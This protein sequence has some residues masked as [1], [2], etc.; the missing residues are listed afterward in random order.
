NTVPAAAAATATLITTG[1]KDPNALTVLSLW[2][3]SEQADFQK[4]LDDFTAQTG[5]KT[6]YQQ[7]RDFIP[8]LR[9]MIAAGNP[10]MVAIIPRPGV[11]ADLVNQNSLKELTSLGVTMDDIKA[12]YS[13]AWIDLGSANNKLYGIAVKAN[14][15]STVWYHP[16]S[17][18]TNNYQI[19]KTWDEMLKLSD[20]MV[21]A[22][23]TPWAVGAGDSWTLTDWFEI[24]YL[25]T[26]GPDKYNQLFQT[27]KLPFTDPTVLN[28]AQ[29]MT[30]ITNT[31]KY[32]PGDAKSALGTKF[33]DGIGLAFGKSPTAEM[34]FE[35]GFVGGIA[36]QQVNPDLKI[37]TDIDFYPFPVIDPQYDEAILGAGDQLS[38]FSDTPQSRAFLKYMISK[39]AAET[40][41][42]TGS[43][44]SPNK[45]VDPAIYPNDLAKKE[46]AQLGAATIFRFDGSDQLPGS[47]ADDWGTAL[48]G[49]V[50]NPADIPKLLTDFD[51]KAAREFGR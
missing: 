39:R 29:M 42:K 43:I 14:S 35:G 15:K 27:G 44:I 26:A 32:V 10:P 11:M 40:W 18:K 23:K 6:Q 1:S 12:S 50:S 45:L 17:F 47:L 16:A 41:A 2:G 22:G 33:V 38:A 31:P 20:Q 36:T 9:T 37:G 49:M 3:G 21:A 13:Q 24:I 28:A 5:I 25:R 30:K 48:Q 7:A 19:P 51:A 46:A 8:A 34:Y 4:V